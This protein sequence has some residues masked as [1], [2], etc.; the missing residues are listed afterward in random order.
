MLAVGKRI[1]KGLINK[2][3]Y[4]Q[5]K[6]ALQERIEQRRITTAC[7]SESRAGITVP[8]KLAKGDFTDR[9]DKVQ[10]F[11]KCYLLRNEIIDED[12]VFQVPRIDEE[13]EK[14]MKDKDVSINELRLNKE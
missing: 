2:R 12:G 8:F 14:Y 5:A 4:F 11:V 9:S 13:L 7:L 3:D 6:S 10:C 1:D